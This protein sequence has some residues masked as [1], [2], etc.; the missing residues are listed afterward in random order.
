MQERPILDDRIDPRQLPRHIA[1]IMDGNGRWAAEHGKPRA[2]GH[3]AGARS[4]RVSIEA[5]REL[6]VEA[7]SLYAFSTENWRRSKTEVQALFR[8]MSKY[9]IHVTH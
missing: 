4:V 6:G 3:E 8:L 1:I 9:R 7:L 2:A 5:C